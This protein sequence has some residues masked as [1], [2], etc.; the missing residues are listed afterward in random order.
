MHTLGKR[1]RADDD[2]RPIG[3]LSHTPSSSCSDSMI[4][5]EYNNKVPLM[6]VLYV[7]VCTP[8]LLYACML[9]GKT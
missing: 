1:S 6:G 9:S 4:K 2:P 5:S 8:V 3:G 7:H